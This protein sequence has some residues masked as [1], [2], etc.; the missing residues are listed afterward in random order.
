MKTKLFFYSA[1]GFFILGCN[2]EEALLYFFCGSHLLTLS[3]CLYFFSRATRTPTADE[4][5]GDENH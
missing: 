3:L 2:A 1:I 5:A 4:T